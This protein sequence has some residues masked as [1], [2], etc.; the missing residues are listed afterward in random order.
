MYSQWPISPRLQMYP[1]SDTNLAGL[2][3]SLDYPAVIAAL[4]LHDPRKERRAVPDLELGKKLAHTTAYGEHAQ[5]QPL[6]YFIV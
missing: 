3:F 6:S 1:F 4:K 2:I 5:V